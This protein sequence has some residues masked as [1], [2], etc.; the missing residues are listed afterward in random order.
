MTVEVVVLAA[1]QGTRM[2][3]NRPKVLHEIGGKAMLR[4]VVDASRAVGAAAVHVVTRPDAEKV[5]AVFGDE[6][7]WVD[8]AEQ[9]GTGHAVLQALPKVAQ[10]SV[11]L[12]VYGD[13]PLVNPDTLRRCVDAAEDGAVALVTAEFSDPAQLGR[14]VRDGSQAIQ[15]IV[16]FKDAAPAERAICEIN[17]G[18]LAAS[19]PVLGTASQRRSTTTILRTS[20]T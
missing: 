16:E 1:G 3:S 14:I 18:I 5:R 11:V 13:V 7:S 19:K 8:Q 17:S 20:T 6:V 2:H 9:L 15:R 4:H 12:V 10:Q